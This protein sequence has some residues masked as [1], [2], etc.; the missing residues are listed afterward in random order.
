MPRCIAHKTLSRRHRIDQLR[1]CGRTRRV[2]KRETRQLNIRLLHGPSIGRSPRLA[3]AQPGSTALPQRPPQRL[4]RSLRADLRILK[5]STVSR[6][7]R[8]TRRPRRQLSSVEGAEEQDGSA[9]W[10]IWDRRD[11]GGT[12][13]S[14]RRGV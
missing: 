4:S 9:D 5:K 6:R 11:P 13:G 12:R 2:A 3:A 8:R 7:S 10:R 1:G 14:R